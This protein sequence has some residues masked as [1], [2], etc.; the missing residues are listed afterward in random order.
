MSDLTQLQ[1]HAS[2]LA[3]ADHRDD[4]MRIHRIVKL[5]RWLAH[6]NL[7]RTLSCPNITG[8]EPHGW[9]GSREIEYDCPG[10]CGGCMTDAERRL[11]RQIADEIDGY[12]TS[13]DEPLFG[14]DS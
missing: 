10:L 4:C 5:D 7:D 8:H 14:G 12:L 3:K 1:E 11:W 9:T 13:D 6:Y 2:R